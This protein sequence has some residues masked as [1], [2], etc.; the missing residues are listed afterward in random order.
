MEKQFYTIGEVA[1]ICDVPIRTLHYY[2]EIGLLKPA[3][4]DEINGYRYYAK[5]Q[6]GLVNVILQFKVQGFTI[7]EMKEQIA[8]HT[9]AFTSDALRKKQKEVQNTIQELIQLE[10]RMHHY[11]D[12]MLLNDGTPHLRVTQ[13]PTMQIAYIREQDAADPG[14]FLARFERLQVLLKQNNFTPCGT[15]MAL[16]HDDRNYT[17]DHADIEVCVPVDVA[18]PI[19]GI[20]RTFGGFE[21]LSAI[22]YGCYETEAQTYAV[23]IAWMQER[24]YI[25][26]GST[27]ENYLID[28]IFTDNE[29]EYVTELMIPIKTA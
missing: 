25:I 19:D 10:K 27:I 8:N 1:K 14:T 4:K 18:N 17:M 16:Y 20:V 29:E 15:L 3:H 9:V 23:M 26:A 11:L 13:V 7:K 5:T 28:W 2:D 6:L 21:V 24:G 12:V 22:H